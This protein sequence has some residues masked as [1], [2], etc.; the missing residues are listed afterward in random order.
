VQM[1]PGRA[2]PV[3]VQMWQRCAQSVPVQMWQR[4][5]CR[6]RNSFFSRSDCLALTRIVWRV[7]LPAGVS[8]NCKKCAHRTVGSFQRCARCADDG[9]RAMHRAAWHPRIAAAGAYAVIVVGDKCSTSIAVTPQRCA[10]V[11]CAAQTSADTGDAGVTGQRLRA[12]ERVEA[13]RAVSGPQVARQ[14]NTRCC[15]IIR[16]SLVAARRKV[17]HRG[18]PWAVQVRMHMEQQHTRPQ[19]GT[20]RASAMGALG[21]GAVGS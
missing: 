13:R 16:C 4:C 17:R 21:F 19:C 9:V 6:R 15:S 11:G 20:V 8:E 1:W 10:Q 12:R 7:L 2:Q 14:H 3:P 5:A 18:R